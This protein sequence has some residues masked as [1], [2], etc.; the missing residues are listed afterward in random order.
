MSGRDLQFSYDVV[1]WTCSLHGT[2]MIK[3][4][5]ANITNTDFRLYI[6][7]QVEMDLSGDPYDCIT[8]RPLNATQIY[9][10]Y[11]KGL[12]QWVAIGD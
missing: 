5:A 10:Y 4:Y 6:G 2:R 12:G 8:I 3:T 11:I 7:G 9:S 1:N